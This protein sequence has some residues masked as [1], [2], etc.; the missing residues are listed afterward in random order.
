MSMTYL[1]PAIIG[2]VVAIGGAVAFLVIRK[3]G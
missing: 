3:R 2:A 1:I